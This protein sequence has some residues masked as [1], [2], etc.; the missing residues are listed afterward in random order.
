[1]AQTG[2]PVGYRPELWALVMPLRDAMSARRLVQKQLAREAGV[3]RSTVSRWLS[4]RTLPPLES[5]L[6][7][8]AHLGLDALTI[9]RRWDL[10]AEVMRNPHVRREAYLAG[11]A[12]P[13]RL[14]SHADLMRALRH[15]LR[16]QGISERELERR[17]PQLRRST[18]G[19]V[20]RGDRG[21]RLDVVTAIVR[22]CGVEGEAAQAW[23]DA[24]ARLSR[25]DLEQRRVRG[26]AYARSLWPL[27]RWGRGY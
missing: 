27:Y 20:L 19:A 16:A 26:E 24:W 3:D 11:G 7:M 12:P 10:A 14:V 5:L 1:M 17:D 9:R 2:V 8:A 21:A 15:L 22:V 4:G 6:L 23:A 25:P 18:V 13:A